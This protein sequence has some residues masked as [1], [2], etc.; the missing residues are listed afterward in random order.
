M[1][2]VLSGG[3][4]RGRL[5][6]LNALFGAIVTSVGLWLQD[7]AR[8]RARRSD[9]GTDIIIWCVPSHRTLSQVWIR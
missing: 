2:V 5:G 6:V 8:E 3:A 9:R 1:A 7:W 4:T